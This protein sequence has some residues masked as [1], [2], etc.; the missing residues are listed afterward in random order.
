[1]CVAVSTRICCSSQVTAK[2]LSTQTANREE[3]G[4]QLTKKISSEIV[5][6][7]VETPENELYCSDRKFH[8]QKPLPLPNIHTDVHFCL[9]T[10]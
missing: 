4:T 2:A 6:P 9:I 7:S 5:A 10:T 3:P 1:M 8:G